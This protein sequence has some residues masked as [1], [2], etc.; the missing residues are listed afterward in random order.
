M[1]TTLSLAQQLIQRPSI[2]P[3]DSGCQTLLA[4]RLSR[5]GFHIEHIDIE[6][7]SN[8]WARI[9]DTK[10]LL[11]LAGHTDVVPT[12]DESLWHYP[13]F[14]AAIEDGYLY[15]RGAADMKGALAAMITATE[16]FLSQGHSGLKGSL[17]FL[18]TSDEE[19]LAKHGTK[20]VLE[21]LKSRQEI[22]TWALI[23]EPSSE[24]KIGDVI[25]V[26]RRGSVT[27]FLIIN[28]KQGHV[29][30]P[31]L[32]LNPIHEALEP[33]QAF[34]NIDFPKS[35]S[36]FPP[37]TLQIANIQAGTG[38]TNVIPQ[39]LHVS[40]NIRFAPPLTSLDVIQLVEDQLIASQKHFDIAW[41]TSGEPFYTDHTS[42]LAKAVHQAIQLDLSLEPTFCTKGGTSDGRFFAQYGTHVVELG[43]VNETIHQINEKTAVTDLDLLS[44]VYE[45]VLKNLLL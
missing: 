41:R 37:T 40:F 4:D 5:L 45:S 33:L 21:T 14:E 1:T 15:G 9:G 28:G 24:K 3:D 26:G 39:Q 42:P 6:G 34:V 43:L 20:A 19:G 10:P 7:V 8:L 22:P 16:R 44:S 36:P 2:T 31:H 35:A 25:K 17:A 27:G 23:G 38:A 13:P 12:G 32:A 29:A 18:I 30:Y 11:C